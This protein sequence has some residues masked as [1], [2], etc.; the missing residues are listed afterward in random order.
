MD[1]FCSSF[2]TNIQPKIVG[3]YASLYDMHQDCRNSSF[4]IVLLLFFAS[5]LPVI[6]QFSKQLFFI[7]SFHTYT[8]NAVQ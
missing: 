8:T 5:I 4:F 1:K 7:F 3:L 2:S 6:Y